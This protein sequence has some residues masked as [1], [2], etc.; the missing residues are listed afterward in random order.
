MDVLKNDKC[1]YD[2]FKWWEAA[3]VTGAL[4]PRKRTSL[5][6][7][8]AESHAYHPIRDS[9]ETLGER[10]TSR[11]E[12][13]QKPHRE[14]RLDS[15]YDSRQ[16]SWRDFSRWPSISPRVSDRTICTTLCKTLS[17]TRFFTRGSVEVKTVQRGGSG[18]PDDTEGLDESGTNRVLRNSPEILLQKKRETPNKIPGNEQKISNEVFHYWGDSTIKSFVSS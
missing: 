6:E 13:R 2:N 10:E 18:S 16:D 7:S 8:L 5:R 9:G 17:E 14:S 4:D 1:Q 11:Q 15:W 12:F 3:A